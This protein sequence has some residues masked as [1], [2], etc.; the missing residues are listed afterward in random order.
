MLHQDKEGAERK[1]T[2]LPPDAE[3][4][5]LEDLSFGSDYLLE[6]TAINANGSSLPSRFNFT[7]GEQPGM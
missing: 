7:I 4:I 5:F 3:S 1:E 6:V 2:K